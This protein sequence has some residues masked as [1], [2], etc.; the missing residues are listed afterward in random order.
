MCYICINPISDDWFYTNYNTFNNTS[1]SSWP[2]Q[3]SDMQRKY[4]IV[5]SEG[6]IVPSVRNTL[7]RHKYLIGYVLHSLSVFWVVFFVVWCLLFSTFF[8]IGYLLSDFSANKFPFYK[9]ICENNVV[10]GAFVVTVKLTS[11]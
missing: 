3:K 4:I 9:I 10:E 6:Q 5:V 8:F 7:V 1:E 11:T 2:Y